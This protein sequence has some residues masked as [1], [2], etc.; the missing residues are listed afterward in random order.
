S[1]VNGRGLWAV[2]YLAFYA[3]SD[4][5]CGSLSPINANGTW[6]ALSPNDLAQRKADYALAATEE[7]T[8]HASA[9]VT[10]WDPAQGNFDA[11]LRNA[12][13]GSKTYATNQDALN[14]MSNALF[15]IEKEVKDWK[16]GRP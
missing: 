6:A 7:I 11:E 12:G 10:A 4:N 14:V 3:G 2:E 5:A 9:I 15:Y 16:I 13:S 1:L 8:K